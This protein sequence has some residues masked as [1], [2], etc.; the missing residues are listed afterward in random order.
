[1]SRETQYVLNQPFAFEEV[2]LS[3]AERSRLQKGPQTVQL[4][5]AQPERV[6][7]KE[8][9]LR[10]LSIRLRTINNA[11][12]SMASLPDGTPITEVSLY[13]SRDRQYLV[14]P[15]GAVKRLMAGDTPLEDDLAKY[16]EKHRDSLASANRLLLSYVRKVEAGEQVQGVI[17][18][19]LLQRI[20]SRTAGRYPIHGIGES[21][22]EFGAEDMASLRQLSDA[23]GKF[24]SEA[25]ALLD[26]VKAW[27]RWWQPW[28]SRAT[29][30]EQAT[31]QLFL[32]AREALQPSN[33]EGVSRERACAA[34]HSWSCSGQA[35]LRRWTV[36]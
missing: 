26:E 8:Y 9:R 13:G 4:F 3:P 25:Q 28:T 15:Y 21:R 23:I 30:V 27:S 29:V 24:E 17:L 33:L 7:L 22:L 16:I 1:M 12:D 14:A 34:L 5:E 31:E 35:A 32:N 11:C 20:P 10:E 6:V 18:S 2:L 36:C 19:S